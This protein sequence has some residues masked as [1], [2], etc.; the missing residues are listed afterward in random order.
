MSLILRSDLNRK[1]TAEELDSNFTYLESISGG[2]TSSVGPTG[3]QGPTGPSGG[4]TSS[5]PDEFVHINPISGLQLVNSSELYRGGVTF[6]LAGSVNVSGDESW[7]SGILYVD[8]FGTSSGV[9]ANNFITGHIVQ[10]SINDTVAY[11]ASRSGDSSIESQIIASTHSLKMSYSDNTGGKYG[12]IDLDENG[13][14]MI[15]NTLTLSNSNSD[16]LLT[17]GEDGSFISKYNNEFQ[18][19]NKPTYLSSFGGTYTGAAFLYDS[20]DVQLMSGVL[21]YRGSTGVGFFS[22]FGD[23]LS[24]V[25]SRGLGLDLISVNSNTNRGSFL[26]VSTQS[27]TLSYIDNVGK[28]ILG[29]DNDFNFTLLTPGFPSNLSVNN[30]EEDIFILSNSGTFSQLN[31]LSDIQF[32]NDE[33]YISEDFGGNTFSIAGSYKDVGAGKVINGVFDLSGFT[34]FPMMG[35]I[36]N[37]AQHSVVSIQDG[38]IDISVRNDSR[39]IMSTQSFELKNGDGGITYSSILMQDGYATLTVS[40]DFYINGGSGTVMTANS[41]D[42]IMDLLVTTPRGGTAGYASDVIA[43]SNGVPIGGLYHN[44]GDVK[45]RVS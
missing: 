34:T 20:G 22:S 25:N 23:E 35:Y 14:G 5:L 9:Y 21:E 18:I 37:N 32:L 24:L 45:M 19:V 43:A 11:M 15:G 3:P 38:A 40:E 16:V 27:I 29:I 1:I 10:L 8:G 33:I 12:K 36:G 13:I 41:T 4:G 39:I 28:S 2:G 7:M 26:T 30:T 42:I 31:T 6:S 17:V 44:G